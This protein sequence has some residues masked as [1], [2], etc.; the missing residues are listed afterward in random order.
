MIDTAASY[1]NEK[2][3]GNAIK[4]SGIAREEIFISSKVFI[5]DAGYEKT[6]KSFEKTL[7]NL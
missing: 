3:V 6:M 1:G 5:Q 2:A 4:N 7:Q